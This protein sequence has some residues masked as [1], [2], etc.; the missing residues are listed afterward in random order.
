MEIDEKYVENV[1]EFIAHKDGENVRNIIWNL[2]PAD[3]AELCNELSV[4][5]ARY[6]YQLLD[7]EKAA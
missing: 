2:H 4:D 6:I 3:I 1:K 7:N 5:E